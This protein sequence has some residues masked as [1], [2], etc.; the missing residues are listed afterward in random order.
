VW[1]TSKVQ[2]IR[3]GAV[4]LV[5]AGA[6]VLTSHA[7]SRDE[8]TD[9]AVPCN[10]TALSAPYRQGN[11]RV[12]SVSSFGCV[13]TY[14]YLWATVGRGVAEVGVTEVLAFDEKTRTW[15]S[16]SRLTYCGHH[17]LPAYVEYWGCNSN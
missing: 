17:R 16:V 7:T 11:F 15:R 14:A 8:R 3:V 4:A 12:D 10:A 5:L 9:L 13:G 6:V 2:G 1:W